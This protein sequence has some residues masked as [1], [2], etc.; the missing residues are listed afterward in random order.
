MPNEQ[1]KN[2][3]GNTLIRDPPT[4]PVI[5]DVICGLSQGVYFN[6]LF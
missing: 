5:T 4:V 1:C 2:A 3:E 6:S